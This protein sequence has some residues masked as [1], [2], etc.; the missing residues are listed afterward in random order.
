M[1]PRAL[2]PAV[3]I[4]A[5]FGVLVWLLPSSAGPS[6][7]SVIEFEVLRKAKPPPPPPE[8][9][10]KPEPPPE[11]KVKVAEK[12]AAAPKE[13]PPE[14]KPA[15]GDKAEPLHFGMLPGGPEGTGSFVVPVGDTLASDKDGPG[16]AGKGGPG[17]APPPPP[18]P[19]KPKPV[20]YAELETE[21]ELV[22]EVRAPYPEEAR[23]KGV[24]GIVVVRIE[25]DEE[26]RVKE[27]VVLSSPDPLLS[28]AA[29]EAVKKFRFKPANRKGK[30]VPTV[31]PKYEYEFVLE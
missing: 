18:P 9:M 1:N 13:T 12:V 7:P 27:V 6:G 22:H 28:S 24:E 16:G 14:A 4:H 3:T 15:E 26:G 2:I 8:P 17:V 30:P 5:A 11:A 25:I 21:P 23:K 31:I 10:L 19:P 20:S 29:I